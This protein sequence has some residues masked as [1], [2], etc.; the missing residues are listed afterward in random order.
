[1]PCHGPHAAAGP[2]PCLNPACLC[3]LPPLHRYRVYFAYPGQPCTSSLHASPNL[4]PL[5]PPP[6]PLPPSQLSELEDQVAG[7][8][9][10]IRDA[11]AA[12]DAAELRTFQ[13]V[14]R[15]DVMP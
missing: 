13:E 3:T 10:R 11:N 5:L 6:P 15:C 8:C 12:F 2:H 4:A 7:S 1:M 9:K 14:M